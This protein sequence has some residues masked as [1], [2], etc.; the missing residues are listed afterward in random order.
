MSSACPHC[1]ASESRAAKAE[2]ERDAI[3]L[4]L[5]NALDASSEGHWKARALD[6]EREFATARRELEAEQGRREAAEADAER[7]AGAMIFM[8]ADAATAFVHVTN[9]SV[10]RGERTGD[11]TMN[12]SACSDGAEIIGQWTA[13]RDA[14]R[15]A[16][17][18][19]KALAAHAARGGGG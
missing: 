3:Q 8:R 10:C 1:L 19:H 5:E 17:S 7:L 15:E 4:Q 13:S 14:A 11:A 12:L 6:A 2:G 9:C 18:V 16:L